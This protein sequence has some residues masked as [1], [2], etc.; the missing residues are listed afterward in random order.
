MPP[1]T[2]PFAAPVLSASESSPAFCAFGAVTLEVFDSESAEASVEDLLLLLFGRGKPLVPG[3]GGR[4]PIVLAMASI[5]LATVIAGGSV[6]ALELALL[7]LV[8]GAVVALSKA[9]LVDTGSD[10]DEELN[11]GFEI[12]GGG[13]LLA[14]E[15]TAAE[16][17]TFT[18]GLVARGGLPEPEIGA[19]PVD[20]GATL[21]ALVPMVSMLPVFLSL[22]AASTRRLAAGAE[23]DD[24]CLTCAAGV[25]LRELLAPATGLFV[26]AAGL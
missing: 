21:V 2:G 11:F 17:S 12:G 15:I 3:S 5:L 1:A 4:P 9:L 22:A 26:V 18:S 10:E 6:A 14:A 7:A 25:A 23:A 20:I 24:D 19:F 16:A 13:F 8:E